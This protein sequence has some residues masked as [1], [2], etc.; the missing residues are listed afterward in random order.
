MACMIALSLRDSATD[1]E[2]PSHSL[3]NTWYKSLAL[4]RDMGLEAPDTQPP[5]YSLQIAEYSYVCVNQEHPQEVI[6]LYRKLGCPPKP[7]FCV[8]DPTAHPLAQCSD[9]KFK[10]LQAE[11]TLETSTLK[12][13]LS[14]LLRSPISADAILQLPNCLWLIHPGADSGPKC[15]EFMT[16]HNPARPM[17]LY[18]FLEPHL[19]GGSCEGLSHA[20]VRSYSTNSLVLPNGDRVLFF[21]IEWKSLQDRAALFAKP[22]LRKQMKTA[23]AGYRAPFLQALGKTEEELTWEE[24]VHIF[25]DSTGAKG[26]QRQFLTGTLAT[27]DYLGQSQG[28]RKRK[29]PCVIF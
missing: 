22:S 15:L 10:A 2:N 7:P 27:N 19:P 28:I 17:M 16:F 12:Q 20:P 1:M 24:D 21:C 4:L 25:F 3:H 8:S 9:D 18:P 29:G 5:D 11:C 23:N 13:L 14:P 26:T 6:Y